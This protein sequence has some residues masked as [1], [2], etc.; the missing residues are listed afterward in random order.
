MEKQREIIGK[1]ISAKN[2]KTITVVVETYRTDSLYKKRVKYSKKY[3]AHD[4]N[5]IAKEG[6]KVLIVETRPISKTKNYK[7]VKILEEAIII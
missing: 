5:N 1:V 7:L 2:D 4:E 6:D 3:C